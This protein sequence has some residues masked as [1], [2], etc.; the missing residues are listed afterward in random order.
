MNRISCRRRNTSRDALRDGGSATI[1]MLFI[2]PAL[3]VILN[4]VIVCGRVIIVH[5]AV[6]NAAQAA[7]RSGSISRIGTL[8][9]G[10]ADATFA[11]VILQNGLH[12]ESG[13]SFAD[14]KTAFQNAPGSPRSFG[15]TSLYSVTVSCT[16]PV[17]ELPGFD[18]NTDPD[19]TVTYTAYSPVDPYRCH[20][21]SSQAPS[22]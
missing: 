14:I 10:N 8:G 1:E 22:C 21:G 18:P 4:L 16:I 5:S 11:A 2:V 20:R 7:A 17:I 3:F 19:V 12:C 6:R 15:A 13:E 9:T